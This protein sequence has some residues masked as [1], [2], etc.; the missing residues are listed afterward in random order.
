MITWGS[1]VKWDEIVF[2]VIVGIT[3]ASPLAVTI[4]PLPQLQDRPV[5][6]KF[7]TFL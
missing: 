7:Y 6:K 4:A 2:Q 5:A 1:G 3:A